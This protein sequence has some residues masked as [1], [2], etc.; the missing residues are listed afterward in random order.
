MGVKIRA[1][2]LRVLED[3]SH[4][5]SVWEDGSRVSGTTVP[6]RIVGT[7]AALEWATDAFDGLG[8]TLGAWEVSPVDPTDWRAPVTFDPSRWR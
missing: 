5:V 8:W 1:A 3:G 7:E 6:A 4:T 2:Y